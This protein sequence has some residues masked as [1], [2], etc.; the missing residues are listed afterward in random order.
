MKKALDGSVGKAPLKKGLWEHLG[1]CLNFRRRSIRMMDMAFWLRFDQPF[2]SHYEK[3]S[4]FKATLADLFILQCWIHCIGWVTLWKIFP[5]INLQ[6]WGFQLPLMT[7]EGSWFQTLATIGT[8]SEIS[9]DQWCGLSVWTQEN[10][11]HF[12]VISNVGCTSSDLKIPFVT[13]PDLPGSVVRSSSKRLIEEGGFFMT[14]LGM[15][16]MIINH[17]Y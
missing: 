7:L 15:L 6:Q 2:P 12:Q 9:T 3:R 5:A 16:N 10:T 1:L 4:L 17:P 14:F 8:H 13:R 11:C